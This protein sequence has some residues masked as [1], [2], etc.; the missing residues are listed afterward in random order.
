M[1]PA[2]SAEPSPVGIAR[3]LWRGWV[4]CSEHIG[5]FQARLILTVMYF[6][7]LAPFA[8]LT[9]LVSRP[10]SRAKFGADSAWLPRTAPELV[11]LESVKRQWSR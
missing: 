5:D 7:V 9:L 10:P 4:E 8:L 3:R 2:P 6:T 1:Q 11:D